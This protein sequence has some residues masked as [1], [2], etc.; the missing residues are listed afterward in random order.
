[1]VA[2]NNMNLP[3]WY[4]TT[5]LL[6]NGTV[7][8]QGGLNGEAYPELRLVNG[9]FRALTT[10]VT[11]NYDYWYPRNFVS[12]DGRIFG[13]DS[14]G[15]YYYVDVNGTGTFTGVN[16]W[17]VMKFGEAGSAVLY[18][19][20]KILQMSGFESSVSI[21]DFTNVGVPTITPT[22][23]MSSRRQNVVGTLLPNGQV[24]ATGGSV[25]YNDVASANKM[26]EI[27]DPKTGKWTAGSSGALARLYHSTAMLQPDG[28]VLVGGGG[29][30]GPL[31]N[32]NVEFY[33]PPYLFDQTTGAL[34]TRPQVIAAS[35]TASVGGTFTISVNDT[36]APITRITM[37]KTP[38][39]THELN[40]DQSFH[41]LAFTRV[42]NVFTVK[43]PTAAT[44]VTPGS[45]LIF[46]QTAAGTPA[47]AR[48]IKVDTTPAQVVPVSTT[49]AIES[50]G[51]TKYLAMKWW[52]ADPAK[53]GGFRD[54]SKATCTGTASQG[55]DCTLG[56]YKTFRPMAFNIAVPP[57]AATTTTSGTPPVTTTNPLPSSSNP[58][59]VTG[60]IMMDNPQF[61]DGAKSYDHYRLPIEFVFNKN[62]CTMKIQHVRT[63]STLEFPLNPP[64]LEILDHKISLSTA[65]CTTYPA[66]QMTQAWLDT[67][68]LALDKYLGPKVPYNPD[69]YPYS[70]PRTGK[71]PSIP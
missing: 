46:A 58:A 2:G 53:E 20:G 4:A 21:I 50:Q 68:N 25:V 34:A 10:A 66:G 11:K 8:I 9:T 52:R 45:Y 49:F 43:M 71:D 18:S 32:E 67:L 39:I 14:Y 26:A 31:N 12:S 6:P 41:D 23:P 22:A 7:Y 55:G 57:P 54:P 16:Q 70:D 42:G 47:Q 17:D 69:P 30:Y 5:T 62:Q 51:E 63:H 48:V 65:L 1:M 38:A 33:Y 59:T 27:W 28:T 44:E 3:R 64:G 40:M 24:L 37:I 60:L 29:A 15:N 19:P 36:A 56:A 61:V 35:Q 13:Y